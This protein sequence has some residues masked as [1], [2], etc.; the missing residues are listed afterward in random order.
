MNFFSDNFNRVLKRIQNQKSFKIVA[1]ECFNDE[2]AN[3]SL[4]EIKITK[5]SDIVL[6]KK[7]L[8]NFDGNQAN[9]EL[10]FS[11]NIIS[12]NDQDFD[13]FTTIFSY[14]PRDN[15]FLYKLKGS[16]LTI[17][18]IMKSSSLGSPLLTSIKVAIK[19][20]DI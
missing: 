19:L 17:S 14:P 18:S 8:F 20:I 9:H 7:K 12:R 16:F 2:F 5:L 10:V 15:N 6:N 13:D 11:L 1:H 3:A 4:D